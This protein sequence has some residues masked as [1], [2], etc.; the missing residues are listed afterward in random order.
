MALLEIREYGKDDVLLKKC[1]PVKELTPRLKTLIEDMLD[2]MYDADGVGLAAPQVGVLRRICVI[3]I[4]EGPVVLI[5]PEV[6]E[7]S[8]EQTGSEGCL[9]VPGKT[10]IV[11]RPNYAK[12]KALNED[13]EEIIVE[14]EELM[15]R[16]LLHE[17]DHLDGNI[18][19]DKVEG[20]LYN[21]E[22]FLE[23]IEDEN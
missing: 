22:D 3:D 23:E 14:G 17:I 7:T 10:G 4:G 20:E 21:V 11:T 16:A 1:K 8:G 13:M 19:V 9:S 12:V 18:Y 6:L 5:N 2:T 15:A